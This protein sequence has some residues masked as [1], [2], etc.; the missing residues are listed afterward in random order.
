V[1]FRNVR[2]AIAFVDELLALEDVSDDALTTQFSLI[3]GSGFP[4]RLTAQRAILDVCIALSGKGI[5]PL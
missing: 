5:L 4:C 1:L 2:S 3:K